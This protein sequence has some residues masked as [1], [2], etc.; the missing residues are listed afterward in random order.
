MFL[1]SLK[2]A[3]E[4]PIVKTLFIPLSSNTRYDIQTKVE[5]FFKE[6]SAFT[7]GILLTLLGFMKFF[8]LI[9]YS[10]FLVAICLAYFF[11]V[12]SLFFEYR[13]V[14]TNTLIST[15]GSDEFLTSKN[16]EVTDVLKKELDKPSSSTRLYTLKLME[17]LEPLLAR[18]KFIE[19]ISTDSNLELRNYAIQRLEITNTIEAI[20]QIQNLKNTNTDLLT[21]QLSESALMSLIRTD[22]IDIS[23]SYTYSLVKSRKIEDRIQACLLLGKTNSDVYLPQIMLLLRDSEVKVRHEAILTCSKI[24]KSETWGILIE[25]LGSYT[26]TNTA[27]SVLISFGEKV[28]PAL[29]AA[30]YKTGQVEQIQEKIVQIYGRIG[31]DVVIKLLWSKIDLPNKKI[32]SNVLLCLTNCGFKPQTRTNKSH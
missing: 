10:Y 18:Q 23:P 24:N 26:F 3:F 17:K 8:D 21:K 19:F 1:Q 9:F 22:S 11:I 29:E 7:A 2:E 25:Y 28:L 31:G 4:D 13:K 6:F 32:V 27:A 16:Y 20:A 12:F 30:F 5:G 15:K 14:L